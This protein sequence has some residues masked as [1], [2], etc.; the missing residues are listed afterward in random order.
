[1]AKTGITSDS[2]DS[3]INPFAP[4]KSRAQSKQSAQKKAKTTSTFT[5]YDASGRAYRQSKTPSVAAT[6]TSRS[7]IAP[8]S[9]FA[10]VRVSSIM[11][12]E[13]NLS[14]TEDLPQSDNDPNKPK[15]LI[16]VTSE[17]EAVGRQVYRG[18]DDSESDDD[19]GYI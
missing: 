16:E 8:R 6:A 3:E 17:A 19:Y 10:R 4:V 5:G 14:P 1:M 18:D 12:C 2:E 7:T 11:C 9:N 13:F 15:G